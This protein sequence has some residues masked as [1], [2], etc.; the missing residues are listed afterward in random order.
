MKMK[1]R[2]RKGIEEVWCIQRLKRKLNVRSSDECTLAC[3]PE[4]TYVIRHSCAL[5]R[6]A[7]GLVRTASRGSQGPQAEHAPL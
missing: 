1:M 3:W 5:P 2:R 7:S 6:R 4:A